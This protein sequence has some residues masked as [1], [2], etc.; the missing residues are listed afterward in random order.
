MITYAKDMIP[1]ITENMRGGNGPVSIMPLFQEK[2]PHVRLLAVITLIP[3]AS[4][5]AHQHID[6][7]E[8]FYALEGEATVVD[9][10]NVFTLQPGDAHLCVDG[11][12]HSLE[13]HSEKT[14]RVLAAIP[15]N[16]E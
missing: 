1:T 15:T 13:N 11:G 12:T 4:I 2:I 8:V 6:E 7:C 14:V 16:A 9:G 10:G 5:G 3:G